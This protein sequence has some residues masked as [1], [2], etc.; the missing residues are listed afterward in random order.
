[1]WAAV[2][3]TKY[4]HGIQEFTEEFLSDF[5]ILHDFFVMG[6]LLAINIIILPGNLEWKLLAI[7]SDVPYNSMVCLIL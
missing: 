5:L 1:M 4:F 2:G 7:I 3:V 6:S